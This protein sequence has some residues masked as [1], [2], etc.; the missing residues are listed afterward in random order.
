MLFKE[1]LR[2]VL[3]ILKTL[4]TRAGKFI[5]LLWRKRLIPAVFFIVLFI[6]ALDI[7]SFFFRPD[8]SQLRK[9][10]PDMTAMMLY[11]EQA[12]K[13]KGKKFRIRKTW[14]PLKRI[15]PYLKEAVIIA[16]DAKFWGHEGFDFEAMKDAI[17][18]DIKARRFKYGAST[19]TQQLAKNLYLKPSRNPLRK[20]REAV[21]VWRL[22]RELT[23][24]RI[25]ELYLNVAEWGEGI[26][27]VEAAA[28]HYFGKSAEFLSP[29][30]AAQL[31]VTLPSPRRFNPSSDSSYARKRAEFIYEELLRRE[32]ERSDIIEQ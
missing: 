19:I 2:S 17:Q 13:D 4:L 18:R 7:G 15:S 25:L 3:S 14:I 5:A 22:E 6:F 12:A 30:E 16:E 24:A 23:K 29:Y 8:V 1:K 9:K 21:L 20:L 10:S 26:Y 32:S 27:G 31:A 28:R 11:K